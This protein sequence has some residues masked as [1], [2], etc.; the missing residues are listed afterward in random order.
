[1]RK[2]LLLVMESIVIYDWFSIKEN[3]VQHLGSGTF[4]KVMLLKFYLQFHQK[5]RK[6]KVSSSNSNTLW[7]G[8]EERRITDSNLDKIFHSN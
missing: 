5:K 4:T 8:H 7:Q 2:Y 1:M 6:R 3:K